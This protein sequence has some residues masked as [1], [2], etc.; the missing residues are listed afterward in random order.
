MIQLSGKNLNKGD[1]VLEFER[2]LKCDHFAIIKWS[3]MIDIKSLKF[4]L[5]DILGLEMSDWVNS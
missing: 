5:F 1:I 3:S 4:Y 2:D